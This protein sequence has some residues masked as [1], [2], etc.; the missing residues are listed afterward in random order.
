MMRCRRN[1]LY[2]FTFF[3]ILG[4]SRDCHAQF[5]T[6]FGGAGAGVIS[7]NRGIGTGFGYGLNGAYFFNPTY[8]AGLFVRSSNH[9]EG[10][11]Y[12]EFGAEGLVKAEKLLNG[13]VLG[14]QLGGSKFSGAGFDGNFHPSGGLKAS[15]DYLLP[16]QTPISIGVDSGIQWTQPKSTI[17]TLFHIFFTAKL[18]LG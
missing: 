14:A 12:F 5:E 3:A 9:S 7:I 4:H 2:I 16:T 1:L 6:G 13:L 17:L 11:T 15:Y 18:Y 10:M 8:G